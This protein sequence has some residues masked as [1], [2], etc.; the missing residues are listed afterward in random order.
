MTKYLKLISQKILPKHKLNE[1]KEYKSFLDIIKFHKFSLSFCT[2]IYFIDGAFAFLL[3][4][5]LAYIYG[6]NNLTLT[7]VGLGIYMSLHTLIGLFEEYFSTPLIANIYN[8]L[9]LQANKYFLSVDPVYHT[10]KSSGTMI[11]KTNRLMRSVEILSNAVNYSLI[12]KLTSGLVAIFYSFSISIE[13]GTWTSVII[14]GLIVNSFYIHTLV[15]NPLN[16]DFI[17][18]ED[19]V[20]KDIVKNLSGFNLI[21][22]S[23]A[24]D[25]VYK[26][27]KEVFINMRKQYSIY[28]FS[29]TIIWFFITKLS[30]FASLILVYFLYKMYSEN[31]INLATLLAATFTSFDAINNVKELGRTYEQIL[32][33]YLDIKDYFDFKSGFGKQTIKVLK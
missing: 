18:A 3:P 16:E 26:E 19:N 25:L 7:I 32:R 2:S 8:S 27:S 11:S 9:G 21:R 14:L 5:F 13:L 30:T 23:F 20:S 17:K 22:S 29:R 28:Y 31:Q 10:N 1:D 4:T 15:I 33:T 6:F 12:P 24:T